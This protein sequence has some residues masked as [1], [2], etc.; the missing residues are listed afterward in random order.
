M[1]GPVPA[2]PAPVVEQAPGIPTGGIDPAFELDQRPDLALVDVSWGGFGGGSRLTVSRSGRAS[3]SSFVF[4]GH[5]SNGSFT[6]S[7]LKLT[8][9]TSVL[10]QARF[11]SLRSD[12]RPA[13]ECPDCPSYS[14]TYSGRM[15]TI[16]RVE[17]FDRGLIPPRLY[18][19]VSL[20]TRLVDA[21]WASRVG[22]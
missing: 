8:E 13:Y 6:L 2:D 19:V 22:A 20:A 14:I 1:G 9:L 10:E 12:Y 7:R 11:R 18:R 16:H 3:V 15:V 5:Q 17:G 21:R 4:G